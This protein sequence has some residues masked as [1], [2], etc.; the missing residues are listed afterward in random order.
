[1]GSNRSFGVIL[2]LVQIWI[3]GFCEETARCKPG[4]SSDHFVF[5]VNRGELERG[6]VLGKVNFDDC[7][8][9]KVVLY[10]SDDSQFDVNADGTIKLKR[11]VKLH[12]GHKSFAVHAWDTKGK[13]TSTR[14]TVENEKRRR[15]SHLRDHHGKH[16]LSTNVQSSSQLQVLTFPQSSIGLRRQKRDWVIPPISVSENERGPFPTFVVKIRSNRDKEITVYYRITGPGANE[17]PEGLFRIERTGGELYVTQPLDRESQAQYILMAHSVDINDQPVEDPMEIIIRVTDQNDNRPAFTMNTFLGNVSEGSPQGTIVMKVT[18][19]DKDDPT[20]D[21][22]I[23]GYS[24]L[25]QEPKEPHSPMFSI[26]K[27][28]TIS[29]V[30]AGL[31]RE[32][33]AEYQLIIQAADMDGNGLSTTATAIITV[34][35]QNDQAPQFKT[36]QETVS[37]PENEVGALVTR[38]AV[39]DQDVPHTPA[40]NAK[41]TIVKGNDGNAF[42]ITTDPSSNEGILKTAKGLDYETTRQ[43]TLFV[44]VKNEEPF[45]STLP[46]ATATITV[47]VE[48]VNEAPIFN[49]LIKRVV[50][51]EN[52]PIGSTVAVYTATDPDKEMKQTVTY[53]MGNDKAGWLEINNNTGVIKVKELMDRESPFVKNNTYT[54]MFL[55]LDNASPP[56]TGTGTL[57]VELTD[58]NDNGPEVVEREIKVCN[59]ET[60]PQI[61]NVIDKDTSVYAGPFNVQVLGDEEKSWTATMNDKGEHIILTMAKELKQ[62][63]YLVILR[64]FDTDKKYQDSRIKAMVCDCQGGDFSC[65]GVIKDANLPAILG[66]LGAILTLLILF[67]ILL[68]LLRRR[69]T[70]KKEPLLPED[71][72]R[73]NVFYYDEEGGGEEDQEYDLSQLH[74]GLDARPDV[75]RNDVVPTTMAVPQYQ[76][77]PR[78]ANPEDISNF[79][80]DNLKAADND[81]TAP[82]YDSLLVFDYEGGGSEAGSVSSLNSSSS[83]DDQ[84][85]DCLNEWGPRFKKLADMYGGG[86]D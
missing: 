66:I 51:E 53:R 8:G 16:N 84:D 25:N 52:M 4:F 17:P 12:D 59:K 20:M 73:D 22:G 74:R 6:R 27:A 3:G 39:T 44:T 71:D 11:R 48:D 24:I 30:A 79:I 55:A 46:T 7:T 32:T 58:V 61:L 76:Y 28:G 34:T 33:V 70:I 82:P 9:R 45:T 42:N 31:D 56:A 43:Y 81:P 37:V 80:D 40:W 86:E 14:V 23:I 21:N 19:T 49:P 72:I 1:M 29:V 47:N 5:K 18:A 35:D 15:H 85:Y 13:R 67:L 65:I 41:Y 54:A 69:K 75:S 60:V 63:D 64:V 50:V 77:R 62:N 83:G 68:L 10:N 26:N 78:P 36:A 38:L 57:V 2:L